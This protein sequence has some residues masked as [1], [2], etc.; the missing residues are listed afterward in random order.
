MSVKLG[1]EDGGVARYRSRPLLDAPYRPV[2][3]GARTG[4][5]RALDM[6]RGVAVPGGDDG[7][8][9][10]PGGGRRAPGRVVAHPHSRGESGGLEGGGGGGG[11][12]GLPALARPV[13]DVAEPAADALEHPDEADR[14]HHRIDVGA[15]EALRGAL[16]GLVEGPC[17]L[18]AAGGARVRGERPG[19]GAGLTWGEASAVRSALDRLGAGV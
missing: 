17:S 10:R 1:P 11:D 5:A 14:L 16:V 12:C 7:T 8:V 19:G 4:V 18:A 9:R 3:R 13:D 15:D 6:R 2:G